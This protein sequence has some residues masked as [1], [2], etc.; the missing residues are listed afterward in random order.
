MLHELLDHFVRGR[1]R[2]WSLGERTS[3]KTRLVQLPNSIAS[4]IALEE[5]ARGP[6]RGAAS[7]LQ[8]LDANDCMCDALVIFFLPITHSTRCKPHL[9]RSVKASNS[10]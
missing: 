5:Q 3:D 2:L 4:G 6:M 8:P 10:S 7:I 9:R 1:W